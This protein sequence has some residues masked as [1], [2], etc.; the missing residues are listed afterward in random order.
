MLLEHPMETEDGG[1]PP[2]VA[3]GG[4]HDGLV[5]QKVLENGAEDVVRE[6]VDS[7]RHLEGE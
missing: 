4:A 2:L 5:D 7:E 1:D 6:V 3:G